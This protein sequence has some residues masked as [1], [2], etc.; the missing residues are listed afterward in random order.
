MSFVTSPCFSFKFLFQLYPNCREL[1]YRRRRVFTF[2]QF[3]LNLNLM[4]L[5]RVAIRLWVDFI[6]GFAPLRSTFAPCA[7]HLRSLLQAQM[8]GVG[9]ERS[10][11]GAK[12]CVGRKTVYEIDPLSQGRGHPDYRV[13]IYCKYQ[14]HFSLS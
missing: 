13:S 1:R 4:L 3:Y 11:Q 6:N 9:R 12:E 5:L 8:L 10:A 2:F 14:A 7:Q